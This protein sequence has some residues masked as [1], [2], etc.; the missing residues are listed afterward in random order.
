MVSWLDDPF[1]EAASLVLASEDEPATKVCSPVAVADDDV[2]ALAHIGSHNS[3]DGPPF[4]RCSTPVGL[5]LLRL[6]D[7]SDDRLI[8]MECLHGTASCEQEL[9]VWVDWAGMPCD[10]E[11]AAVFTLVVRHHGVEIVCAQAP[12]LEP[13][14][15]T[16]VHTAEPGEPLVTQLGWAGGDRWLH[17]LAPLPHLSF[18]GLVLP[19]QRG[20]ASAAGIASL[21]TAVAADLEAAPLL[22]SPSQRGFG[23]ELELVTHIPEAAQASGPPDE[24]LRQLLQQTLDALIASAQVLELTDS[25]KLIAALDRCRRWIVSKDGDIAPTVEGV[26][27]RCVEALP[28]G[29]EDEGHMHRGCMALLMCALGTFRSEFKSPPPPHNLRF[30]AGAATE[31]S[32]FIHGVLGSIGAAAP[33]VTTD[34]NAGTAL[35]VHVNVLNPEAGGSSLFSS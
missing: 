2:Y 34:G 6:V 4:L 10:R 24:P 14:R 26:A 8:G 17:V 18:S 31:I 1:D 27:R 12:A 13:L 16:F 7:P 20:M 28:Q 32:S 35:H 22:S 9:S 15:V 3:C 25:M 33:S 11:D 21:A 30:S 19:P 23:V 5:S 29:T